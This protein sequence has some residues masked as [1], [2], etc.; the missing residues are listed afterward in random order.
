MDSEAKILLY[1]PG[2]LCVKEFRHSCCVATGTA[3]SFE[4]QK[5]HILLFSAEI[6]CLLAESSSFATL[7]ELSIIHKIAEN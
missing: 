2:L 1:F 6:G 5:S 7:S 4:S 3:D